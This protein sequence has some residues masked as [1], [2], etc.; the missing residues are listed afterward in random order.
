MAA[1]PPV[2]SGQT[3]FSFTDCS[4]AGILL[5]FTADPAPLSLRSG[6]IVLVQSTA[7]VPGTPVDWTILWGRRRSPIR[8]SMSISRSGA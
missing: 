2:L 3:S 6:D 4:N 8:R 5:R 7:G 1:T